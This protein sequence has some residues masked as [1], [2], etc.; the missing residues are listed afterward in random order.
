[1]LRAFKEDFDLLFN[2]CFFNTTEIKS[3]NV[4]SLLSQTPNL[5]LDVVKCAGR[6]TF[7]LQIYLHQQNTALFWN[8]NWE[9]VY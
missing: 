5:L 7:N 6:R 1:M 2:K 3:K 8:K 4:V 9:L